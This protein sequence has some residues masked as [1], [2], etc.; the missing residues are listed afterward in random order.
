M[1]R[2][3]G[4]ST[5]GSTPGQSSGAK[6]QGS[7][8]VAFGCFPLVSLLVRPDASD[9]FSTPLLPERIVKGQLSVASQIQSIEGEGGISASPAV[10]VDLLLGRV[11][12]G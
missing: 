4:R 10:G 9:Q 12:S 11:N 3:G 6:W 1:E 5:G 2:D 8:P 7:A